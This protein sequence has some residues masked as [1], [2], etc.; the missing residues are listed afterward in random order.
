MRGRGGAL[1]PRQAAGDAADVHLVVE[2]GET[3]AEEA[4]DRSAADSQY[5]GGGGGGVGG[6]GFG[7]SSDVPLSEHDVRAS[8]PAPH[9]PPADV[10]ARARVA[11]RPDRRASTFAWA[12]RAPCRAGTAATWCTR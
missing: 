9:R 6:S 12:T 1:T 2:G 8:A 11:A 3:G 5:S 7:V 10:P 4:V